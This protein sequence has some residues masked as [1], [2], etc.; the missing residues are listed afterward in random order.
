MG[1]FARAA[2]TRARRRDRGRG[3][4]RAARQASEWRAAGIPTRIAVNV[5][6]AQLHDY[7]PGAVRDALASTGAR[8]GDII[9]EITESAASVDPHRVGAIVAELR[10]LGVALAIDDFGAGQSSLGRLNELSADYLKLDRSL[11]QGVPETTAQ[12]ALVDAVAKM[13][14][15]LGLEPIAEGIE[16]ADQKRFASERGFGLAQG[17]GLARPQPVAEVTALLR[18]A[19]PARTFSER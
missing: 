4:G 10:A 19:R 16:T 14:T 12:A 3:A 18:A 13:A 8:A 1:A 2:D 17:F 9:I 15:A 6:A 7:F 11:L 5:S